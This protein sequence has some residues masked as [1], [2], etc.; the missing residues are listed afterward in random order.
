MAKKAGRKRLGRPK[1]TGKGHLIG[2]RCH[3][4][5]LA[6]V[7]EW[8]EE[9]DEKPSRPAAIVRLAELGLK[10]ENPPA[11]IQEKDP[12]SLADSYRP[13]ESDDGD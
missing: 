4:P 1:T 13:M 12:K 8:R 10:A 6:A 11:K 7:D 2:L 9:Q 5:F 3:K